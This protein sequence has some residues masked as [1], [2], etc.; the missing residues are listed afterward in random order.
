MSR[1]DPSK[2]FCFLLSCLLACL[3]CY[4]IALLPCT[5][6]Q[7]KPQGLFHVLGTL[8]GYHAKH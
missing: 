2:A 8:L 1:S 3:V 6:T 7:I 4:Y 5:T